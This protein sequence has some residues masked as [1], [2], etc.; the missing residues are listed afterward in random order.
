MIAKEVKRLC[1][2]TPDELAYFLTEAKKICDY[3][4]DVMTNKKYFIHPLY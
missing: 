2:L 4:L 3:N 1:E